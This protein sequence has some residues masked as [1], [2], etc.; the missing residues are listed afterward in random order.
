MGFRITNQF[1]AL[2]PWLKPALPLDS[3]GFG[4][5]G[6]AAGEDEVGRAS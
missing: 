5:S 3:Q 2:E 4:V 1:A 6:S